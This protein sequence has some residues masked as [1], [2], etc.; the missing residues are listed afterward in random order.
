[1]DEVA[2]AV[3]PQLGHRLHPVEGGQKT[4]GLLLSL[5]DGPGDVAGQKVQGWLRTFG[6]DCAWR[7]ITPIT[8]SLCR[9]IYL[10]RS[11]G[12]YE[13]CV[14]SAD[15]MLTLVHAG[16]VHGLGVH[17]GRLFLRPHW[18]LQHL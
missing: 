16:L 8:W 2:G 9:D 10:Q 7:R 6:F 4:P 13:A 12:Q 3:R 14:S 11:T 1:M 17:G 15:P 5:Q 18:L